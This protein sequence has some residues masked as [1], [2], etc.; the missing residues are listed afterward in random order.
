MTDVVPAA[1]T[2]PAGP[3]GPASAV[4]VSTTGPPSARRAGR[5]GTLRQL[6]RPACF[7]LG[8]RLIVLAVT[9]TAAA[10]TRGLHPVHTLGTIFDGRW[11]VMIAQHGYPHQ[12]YQEGAGS[13]WAFFPAFPLVIR[14]LAEVTRIPMAGAAVL[15]AFVL[16]LSAAL[17]VWLAVRE[18]LG[19]R[20][21]DG[22]VLLLVFFPTAY[23]LSLAY[24]EGLFLTAAA[25]CLLA[26]TRRA[27]LWAGLCACVAGLTRNAG[28][29][30]VLAVVATALPAAWRGR[31]WRPLAGVAIAPLG[32]GA[33]MAYGWTTVG[34]PTAFLA[35][36]RFWYGQ[37]FVW[38]TTPVVSTVSALRAGPFGP[39]FVPDA[40]A[41]AAL[42]L[43][44]LGVWWL[45]RMAAE[46][47]VLLDARRRSVPGSWWVYTVGSLLVAYSA[48][49]SV[50]IARYTMAAFP[51]FAALAWR[52]RHHRLWPVVAGMGLVQAALFLDVLRAVHPVVDPLVP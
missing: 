20:L 16:G 52:L 44:F 42:A 3:T 45:D 32:L 31:T 37:H 11:Y 5:A 8:S 12:L 21:A 7:Y 23:V 35:A 33:F 24:T 26:L 30:V 10:V 18:V 34:T 29:V 17:A 25:L 51:L 50:S 15:A 22:A 19:A 49:F 27:W 28:A 43:G 46:P 40:L 36:E 6:A 13:R 38:F 39:A 4:D 47:G 14:A 41:G 48:Y 9:L 1:V 2:T